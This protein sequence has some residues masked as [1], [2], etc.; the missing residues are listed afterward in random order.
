MRTPHAVDVPFVFDNLADPGFA[1]LLGDSPPQDVADRGHAAWRLAGVSGADPLD[2]PV[3]GIG[4]ALDE[5][6]ALE[7]VH[8]AG[9]V[10]SCIWASPTRYRNTSASSSPRSGNPLR[11]R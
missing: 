11:R 9:Q 5:A 7:P 3:D 10:G 4:D 2:P 6:S 8:H 1:P